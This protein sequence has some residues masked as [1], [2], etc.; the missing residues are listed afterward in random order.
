MVRLALVYAMC[1][2]AL[3]FVVDT[4]WLPAVSLWI[5]EVPMLDKVIHF[6]LYG[7]LALVVNLALASRDRRSLV[8]AVVLGSLFAIIV[9]T[10][11]EF[12]N[13]FI[14]VRD[15]SL[16]DLAANYLGVLCVGI[17]PI[18]QR[19]MKSQPTVPELVVAAPPVGGGV[20][21]DDQ[22]PQSAANR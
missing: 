3:V 19:S 20:T 15:W 9:S 14:A 2:I 7:T 8:R 6:S 22:R 18:W 4:G 17:L 21:A 5:H 11:D 10:T 12:S 16:G 1:L 13:R